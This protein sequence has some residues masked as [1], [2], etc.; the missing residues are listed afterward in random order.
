MVRPV[1]KTGRQAKATASITHRS[2]FS[3]E[4]ASAKPVADTTP[5]S[6]RQ[7]KMLKMLLPTTLPIAMPRSLWIAAITGVATSGM[8]VPAATTVSRS[9]GR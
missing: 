6:P 9:P 4:G 5:A 1:R 8:D 7:P 2:K 3:A